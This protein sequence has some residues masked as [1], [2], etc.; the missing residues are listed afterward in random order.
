MPP[1]MRPLV[2]HKECDPDPFTLAALAISAGGLLISS[3]AY[4]GAAGDRANKARERT[5]AARALVLRWRKALEAT[6]SG[7]AE[8]RNSIES[9]LK[10]PVNTR[11]V[12]RNPIYLSENAFQQMNRAVVQVLSRTAV[13]AALSPDVAEIIDD[14][15]LQSWFVE[16]TSNLVDIVNSLH[17]EQMMPVEDLRRTLRD[18]LEA[19]EG[20]I[21][22]ARELERRII[23]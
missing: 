1:D 8:L 15:A 17:I 12:Y 9:P 23:E 16:R 14:A 5:T 21:R 19:Y 13:V 4:L 20:M 2:C 10:G 3:V 22:V 6:A 7:L 18:V 11:T